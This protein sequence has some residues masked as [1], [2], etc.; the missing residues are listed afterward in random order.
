MSRTNFTGPTQSLSDEGGAL[1]P[2][3]LEADGVVA[4]LEHGM[5]V[6]GSSSRCD[7]VL[8]DR[9]VSGRHATFELL[10]GAVRVRDL[11]SRNG[12]RFLGAKVDAIVVPVGA[13]VTLGKTV[14][15]LGRP[16][17]SAAAAATDDWHGLVGRS[18]AM[19]QLVWRLE[20]A[21][22]TD[23]SVVLRGPTGAGKEAVARALHAAS[24]R[25]GRPFVVF[26]GAGVSGELL[27]SE[28]FGHVKGAFTGAVS[29][30]AGVLEL[31]HGG[32]VL[33]DNI[34]QMPLALQPRLLRFLEARQLRRVGDTRLKAVDVRVV[35]TTQRGLERAVEQGELR[36]DLFYRLA[37]VVLDVPAL[38]QRRE[39]IRCLARR[40]AGPGV[41][42]SPSTL[43]SLEAHPWPGNARELKHA[44]ERSL[45]LGTWEPSQA[46][47]DAPPGVDLKAARARVSRAFEADALEAL[48]DKHRW[49]VAAVA[50]EAKLARSHL[51]TLI[52]KHGLKRR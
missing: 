18:L 35:S 19:R 28:L 13:S 52:Q 22:K 33:F 45:T 23:V 14:V 15:Q 10:P 3:E 38:H 50:R 12:V 7:L 25:A 26:D 36:E 30:K 21:A 44:V 43:A 39:D 1:E 34:D 41:K 37:A 32:T 49:N 51:Y 46:P 27:E 8:E 9:T 48:L 16:K 29:A 5:L 40:F 11:G 20:R 6:A 24:A 31:A 47:D 17:D 2:V 42:L 4:R